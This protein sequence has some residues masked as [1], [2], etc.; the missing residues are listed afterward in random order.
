V[1]LGVVA[2]ALFPLLGGSVRGGLQRAWCRLVLAALGVRLKVEGE[3]AADRELVVANHVSWLDVVALSAVRPAVF[4]C[5]SEIAAWPV[6]GRLLHG[7]GTVFMRRGSARAA[8][9]AM[10]ELSMLLAIG[11]RAAVFPEGTTTRGADVLPFRPALLQSALNA[12]CAIR[13]VALSYTSEVAVY[14]G[15]ISFLAS[16]WAIAGASGLQVRLVLL[17]GIAAAGI[18]R[19]EAAALA[20]ELILSRIRHES[21]AG[22]SHFAPTLRAA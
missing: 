9:R 20:R 5:K 19:R 1:A 10:R 21:L 3:A 7:A 17:P 13:P 8:Y 6:F 22:A 11:E 15:G 14:E 2:T 16:L 4:V 18:T 12:G